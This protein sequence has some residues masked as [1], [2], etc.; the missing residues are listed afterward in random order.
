MQWTR[1]HCCTSHCVAHE[2]VGALHLICI[3]IH[4][5]RLSVVC[6]LTLCSSPCSFP[7]VSP[8]L[9]PSTSTLSWTSSSLWTSSGAIFHW[10]S[11]NWG[12]WHF[13]RKHLSHNSC[14]FDQASVTFKELDGYVTVLIGRGPCCEWFSRVVP[15]KG[16]RLKE[17]E[18]FLAVTIVFSKTTSIVTSA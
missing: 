10:H 6:S 2:C 14:A 17:L 13:G 15:R 5:M 9:S 12:V 16:Q 3:V 18:D 4:V 8:I 11:A 1:T 7:C